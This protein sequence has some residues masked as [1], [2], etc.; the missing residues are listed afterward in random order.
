MKQKL[1]RARKGQF[2][3]GVSGNPSGRPVGSLNKS[4]LAAQLLQNES[5]VLVQT[6]IDLAK[7]G[8]VLALRV[9]IERFVPVCKERSISLELEPAASFADLPKTFQSVFT[10]VAE[11]RITPAEG[12]TLTN[13]LHLQAQTAESIQ[14]EQRLQALEAFSSEVKAYQKESLRLPDLPKG[15]AA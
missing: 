12:E 1:N 2:Q 15:G 3:K 10:A 11:G 6:L 9:C 4:T 5:G 13:M 14:M 7:Q 8:N